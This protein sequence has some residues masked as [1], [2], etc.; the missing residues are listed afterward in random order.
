MG[1]ALLVIAGAA[2]LTLLLLACLRIG[3]DDDDREGRG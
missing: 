3:S 2:F 1:T